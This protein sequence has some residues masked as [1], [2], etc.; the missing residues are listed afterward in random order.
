MLPPCSATATSCSI[1]PRLSPPGP[2]LFSCFFCW[3]RRFHKRAETR[4]QNTPEGFSK[5]AIAFQTSYL[6]DRQHPHFSPGLGQQV[7]KTHMCSLPKYA[8]PG[9]RPD[10][11]MKTHDVQDEGP[12]VKLNGWHCV[13]HCRHPQT[14]GTGQQTLGERKA[15]EAGQRKTTASAL[16][17]WQIN[18][19]DFWNRWSGQFWGR[20]WG[21]RQKH[22]WQY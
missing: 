15:N 17:E 4:F 10:S 18:D 5:H 3:R 8:L 13:P 14:T 11:W 21:T 9:G 12:D 1:L 20:V 2:S 7:F 6:L 22:V 16:V 19:G